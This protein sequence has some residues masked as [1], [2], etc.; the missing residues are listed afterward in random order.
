M[1]LKKRLEQRFLKYSAISSQSDGSNETIPSSIGQWKMAETL[2]EDLKDLGVQDVEFRGKKIHM[3]KLR[4]PWGSYTTQYFWNEKKQ[5][6]EF[7]TNETESSGVFFMELT[8]FS[9]VFRSVFSTDEER[10]R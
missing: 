2:A 4:N 1:N 6:M 5:E 8:H 7:D 9:R 10:I 3:V